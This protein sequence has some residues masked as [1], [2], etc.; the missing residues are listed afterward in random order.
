[1]LYS[2]GVIDHDDEFPRRLAERLERLGLGEAAG[3]LLDAV[4]PLTVVAAQL[5]LI[6]EPLFRGSGTE[7]G[8]WARLLQ[9]PDQV[10]DLVRRLRREEAA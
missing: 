6:A 4:G 8:E 1:M 7:L 10:S 2:A 3:V 9:D 5:A